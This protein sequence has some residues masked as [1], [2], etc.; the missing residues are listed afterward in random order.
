[1]EEKTVFIPC[2]LPA[3]SRGQ[4]NKLGGGELE[5][6]SQATGTSG[7]QDVR[8]EKSGLKEHQL[9]CS[10]MLCLSLL[11][12]GLYLGRKYSDSSGCSLSSFKSSILENEQLQLGKGLAHQVPLGLPLEENEI[13][14]YD[15]Y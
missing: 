4:S 8:V 13:P 6:A 7:S 1:M 2:S 9:K 10:G 14:R 12:E 3:D 11:F 5:F 15:Y